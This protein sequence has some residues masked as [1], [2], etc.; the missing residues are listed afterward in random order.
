MSAC[1]WPRCSVT[2]LA[3]SLSSVEKSRCR[4]SLPAKPRR[5]SATVRQDVG[6]DLLVGGIVLPL[7][8]P[9]SRPGHDPRFP[10]PGRT[11][12]RSRGPAFRPVFSE[13][14]WGRS[15]GGRRMGRIGVGCIPRWGLERMRGGG[16]SSLHRRPRNR[17]F[18]LAEVVCP[19]FQ[20]ECGVRQ[21]EHRTQ[22]DVGRG[23]FFDQRA[24]GVGPVEPRDLVAELEV[25][26]DVLHVGRESVQVVFEVGLEL[27]PAG[28]GPQVVQGEHRGVVELLAGRLPQRRVLVD[29]AHAV[30][31]VLH[32]Q[33]G[34]LGGSRTASRRRSTVMGRMTSRYLPR[35]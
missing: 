4:A 19:P 23:E 13:E 14:R 17:K 29:D 24:Q 1:R 2:K 12:R 11:A 33:D 35:T 3:G 10:W 28:S 31:R 8:R 27:L 5:R 30:Q 7:P 34:L 22:V 21:T 6:E 16:C 9:L 20:G 32:V 18:G 26:E 15:E 25:L